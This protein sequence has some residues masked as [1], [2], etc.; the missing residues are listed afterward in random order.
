MSKLLF[1]Y[2]ELARP[3]RVVV[4]DVAVGVVGD[5]RVLEPQLAVLRPNVCF[6]HIRMAISNRLRFGPCQD[7]PGLERFEDMV[8]VKGTTIVNEIPIRHARLY[9]RDKV[10]PLD[11]GG[12]RR[13]LARL[14]AALVVAPRRGKAGEGR[15][16]PKVATA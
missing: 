6:A 11:C 1:M 2:Q 4:V 8:V 7:E 5:V 9:H 10:P 14:E 12:L 13:F 16:S 3:E 15:R